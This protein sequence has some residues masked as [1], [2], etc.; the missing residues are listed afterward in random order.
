MI[1]KWILQRYFCKIIF[2]MATWWIEEFNKW[3]SGG[4][5]P[6]N[7]VT[8]LYLH[9]Y[10]LTSLP[11]SIGNLTGLQE[12][13]IENNQLTSLPESIGNLTGLR[14]LSVE[15]NQLTSLPES[16]GN[17]TALQWLYLNNNQ[18]TSLPDSIMDIEYI[19]IVRVD[20]YLKDFITNPDMLKFVTFEEEKGDTKPAMC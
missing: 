2:A 8:L 17:L 3:I 7:T 6:D 20:F 5:E 1:K 13:Y 10:K 14:G 19:E 15:L 12:L 11:D 16:I 18:L 4:C 9:D